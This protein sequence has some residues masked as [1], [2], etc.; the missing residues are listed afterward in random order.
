MS[1]ISRPLADDITHYDVGGVSDAMRSRRDGVWTGQ[2]PISRLSVGQTAQ[3]ITVR[4]FA[5]DSGPLQTSR[6]T[7]DTETLL[8]LHPASDPV[9]DRRVPLKRILSLSGG[10]RPAPAH[11]V[12]SFKQVD[13]AA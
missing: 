12:P 13:H 7:G 8:L 10:Q 3:L 5:T 2:A 1:R 6:D 11:R 4:Q 9:T